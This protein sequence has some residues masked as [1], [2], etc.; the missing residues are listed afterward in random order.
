M[1]VD[2]GLK[3]MNLNEMA[4]KVHLKI[5]QIVAGFVQKTSL[6]SFKTTKPLKQ[7][8][9]RISDP[10]MRFYLKMIEPNLSKISANGFQNI[11][12]ST[13]A[14]FDAHLGLQLEYLLLQN[15]S[16]LLKAIGVS[17]ADIVCDGP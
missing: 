12:L 10:Y 11:S 9:Y 17:G 8:L 15:R 2:A 7:S 16:L 5:L 3:L 13:L 4:I 14:G 1:N 6:W